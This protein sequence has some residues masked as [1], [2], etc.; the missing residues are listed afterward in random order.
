MKK[1]KFAGTLC[2]ILLAFGP[3]I[4]VSQAQDLAPEVLHYAD[5]VFYNGQ[6]LTMD[7]DQPPF[8]VAQALAV[9][10]GRIL[11]VGNDERILK[12]AG[13]SDDWSSWKDTPFY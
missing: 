12:T 8:T 1:N 2:V 7:R 13:P 3:A 5:L 4:R 6:V 11:A 9:R 10:D